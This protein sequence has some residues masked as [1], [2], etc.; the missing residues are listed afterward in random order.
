MGFL[1]LLLSHPS[2]PTPHMATK[3]NRPAVSDV[4]RQ[5][6][7]SASAAAPEVVPA[8]A[9]PVPL[10]IPDT[11]PAK[12]AEKPA[13]QAA[14]NEDFDRQIAKLDRQLQTAKSRETDLEQELKEARSK[15]KELTAAN[16][17]NLK[18]AAEL[19]EAKKT[20]QQ[21]I[22][23]NQAAPAPTTTPKTTPALTVK[24]QIAQPA[25]IHRYPI[26]PIKTAPSRSVPDVG[27]MD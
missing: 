21:L 12:P 3:K 18:L 5:E 14:S 6:T 8:A 17:K 23:T 7:Q 22:E 16:E 15:I 4:V 20:I 10:K 19:A 25:A 26:Q 9:Q 27:W 13:E 1:T 11:K 24:Q 2:P